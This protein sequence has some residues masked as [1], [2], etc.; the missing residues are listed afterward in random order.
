MDGKKNTLVL[1]GPLREGGGRGEGGR[2]GGRKGGM[3]WDGIWRTI[4]YLGTTTTN[5][6]RMS[7]YVRLL[8]KKDGFPCTS[9]IL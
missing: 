1:S 9:D 7:K 6:A 4:Y 8:H 3:G 2:K 5:L